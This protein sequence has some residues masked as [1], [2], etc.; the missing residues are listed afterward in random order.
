MF[1]RSNFG[2]LL[3]LCFIT[4]NT[5][6]Q[7]A[8]IPSLN[9]GDPAPAL[10]VGGWLK[11]T[12]IQGFE[13]GKVYVVEFWATWC[14]PC[15]A[16]MPHLSALAREF[17]DKVTIIGID[18]YENKT[19]F[20]QKVRAFVDSM[21]HRMDYNV[22]EDDSNFMVA[23]WIDACG[24]KG[25]PKSFVVDAEGR[26]AWFGHPHNLAEV[27]SKIVNKTWDIKEALAKRNLERHLGELEES[28]GY[29]LIGY[30]ADLE[31][32]YF[33]KPD[34]ALRA[35][36]E[37]V[38]K[39]PKLKF[40]PA[41]VSYTFSALLITN[42]NKA[43]EYGEVALTTS[44]YDDPVYHIIFGQ[45]NAFSDKL[46][47]PAEIYELGAEAYQARINVYPETADLL[48]WYSKMA[49]WYWRAND[50]SKAIDAQEKA[51]EALRNQKDYSQIK[52][53]GLQFWLKRYKDM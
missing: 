20:L 38:R 35:I 39:E 50:K 41:I 37:I 46:S 52:M 18:S 5:L 4:I 7:D 42:P 32:D 30:S 51:I 1:V 48:N 19:T 3:L 9:I 44:A 10:L 31:K 28:A 29:E 24:E 53:A 15:I 43:Y 25:I 23:N 11:G 26:V 49:E 21:G 8:Q 16:A 13:R 36:N 12:P 40:A 14:K 34:S 22:A 17:K 27:L 2:I 45:I 6:G 47:L 33:G